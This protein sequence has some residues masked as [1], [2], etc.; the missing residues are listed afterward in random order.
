MTQKGTHTWDLIVQY[1]RCP[2][3]GYIFESR[4]D[5]QNR[6]GLYQKDLQ[7]PRCNNIY[8]IT[9]DRKPTFGP[10]TG[11]PQPIEVDWS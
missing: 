6:L 10:L 7:C 11:E 5:Y 2:K 3:C 9:K 4:E 8:T 1:H